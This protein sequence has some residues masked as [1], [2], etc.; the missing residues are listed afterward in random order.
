MVKV[1]V[2]VRPWRQWI[3]FVGVGSSA[4]GV[5]FGVVLA[6]V[7][8]WHWPPLTANVL[9]WVVAFGVSYGGHQWLTFVQQGAAVGQSLPRFALLSALGFALN[10]GLYAWA[11]ALGLDFRLGLFLVLL[12]VAVLTYVLSQRW[13]FARSP[14]SV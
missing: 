2:G 12:V 4:A 14:S 11:L 6:L 7:S 9:A 1:K 3:T 13:A 5:H 8:L 10:E